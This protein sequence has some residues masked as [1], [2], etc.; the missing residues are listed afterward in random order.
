MGWKS[1][2]Y[3]ALDSYFEDIGV[4]SRLNTDGAKEMNL[5]RWKSMTTE[6]AHVAKVGFVAKA[7]E[8]RR[9]GLVF[10]GKGVLNNEEIAME[11]IGPEVGVEIGSSEHHAQGI[12]NGL[13]GTFDGAVLVRAVSAGGQNIVAMTLKESANFV[14]VVKFASLVQVD[15]LTRDFG[16]MLLQPVIKPV[17]GGAFGDTRSAAK[18][19][20]GVVSNQILTILAIETTIGS[21]ASL[22]FGALASKGK[23]NG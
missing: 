23:I 22:D 8:V 20:G 21:A 9:A 11:G 15:L 4:R 17:E 7:K 1:E 12:A 2:A 18:S 19:T 14:V 3:N 13:V 5:G 10:E 6:R 16:S